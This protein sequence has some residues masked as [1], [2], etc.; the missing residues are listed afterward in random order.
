LGSVGHRLRAARER[1]RERPGLSGGKKKKQKR[2]D[3]RARGKKHLLLSLSWVIRTKKLYQWSRVCLQV[4]YPVTYPQV[5]PGSRET[6]M[7]FWSYNFRF[8]GSVGHGL[9]AG[10]ERE[11]RVKPP[12]PTGK[13]K[14]PRKTKKGQILWAEEKKTKVALSRRTERGSELGRALAMAF[15]TMRE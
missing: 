9:R 14:K 7:L 11:A 3:G 12:S 8:F 1:E 4:C 13:K 15:C 10:R 6:C 5:Y 2:A